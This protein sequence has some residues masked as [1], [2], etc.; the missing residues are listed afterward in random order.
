MIAV[1]FYS[2]V[3]GSFIMD[4]EQSTFTQRRVSAKRALGKCLGRKLAGKIE[5]AIY[6]YAEE[7]CDGSGLGEEQLF[8][9]YC[10]KVDDLV[11][12]FSQETDDIARHKKHLANGK[13]DCCKLPYLSPQELQPAIWAKPIARIILTE[14]RR[15]ETPAMVLKPCKICGCDRH[16]CHQI[17]LRSADEAMTQFQ[18]CADCGNVVRISD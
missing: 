2:L 11:Y 1:I 13:L 16:H 12:N 9:I 18:K 7:Y 15:N 6:Q 10:D 17:Q 14:Q 4:E 5:R 8:S 3:A